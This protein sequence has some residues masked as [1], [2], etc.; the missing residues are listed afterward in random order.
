MFIISRTRSHDLLAFTADDHVG[1][2][3][4]HIRK[5]HSGIVSYESQYGFYCLN[6]GVCGATIMKICRRLAR[7]DLP[8]EIMAAASCHRIYIYTLT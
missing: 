6:K 1:R 5:S 2:Y 8:Q 3:N 4:L 7:I